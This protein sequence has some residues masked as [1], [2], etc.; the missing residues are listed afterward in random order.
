M[1]QGATL[2]EGCIEVDVDSINRWYE[3]YQLTF[4]DSIQKAWNG[5]AIFL[6]LLIIVFSGIWPYAKN[7]ILIFTWYAPLTVERR[8]SILTWLLRLSKYTLVDVFAVVAVLVGVQLE[9][10]IAGATVV[11][12][13]EPRPSII[14]FFVATLWEFVQIEWTVH[15]HNRHVRYDEAENDFG[16]TEDIET[17]GAEGGKHSSKP[18]ND[19]DDGA[20]QAKP[21]DGN[22]LMAMRFR[23]ELSSNKN[24]DS[25]APISVAGIY[26]WIG[27]LLLTT[28]VMFLSGALTELVEFTTSSIASSNECVKSYN[29]VSFG[30]GLINSLSLNQSD[31]PAG[32]WTLYLAYIFLVVFLPIVVHTMQICV[33]AVSALTLQS[34]TGSDGEASSMKKCKEACHVMSSLFGFSSIEVLLIGIFAVQHKF[35]DFVAALAGSGNDDF[36]SITS[37]IGNGFYILIV[38]SLASGLLQYFIHC[39]ETEY[40]KID[41]YHKVHIVWTKLFSCWLKKA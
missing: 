2:S 13:A 3:V 33:L 29:L 28:I 1:L 20:V 22:F 34:K 17:S 10:N 19:I 18:T 25:V 24:R 38:Y 36:F 23:T 41:P 4:V 7:I 14:A 21:S 5:D 26:A 9:L 30:G 32:T 39:C 11:T 6:A 37:S 27:F 16:W 8:D 35:E 15:L 40:F 12:R 31:S